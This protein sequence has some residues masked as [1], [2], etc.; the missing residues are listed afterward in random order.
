MFDFSLNPWRTELTKNQIS[1]QYRKRVG[2]RDQEKNQRTKKKTRR[3]KNKGKNEKHKEEETEKRKR[4]R[5][6]KN[7]P[8]L[9]IELGQII[10]SHTLHL[11]VHTLQLNNIKPKKKEAR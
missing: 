4:S 2:K 8:S 5:K 7:L 1:V 6:V 10:S 11:T 3:E 9:L